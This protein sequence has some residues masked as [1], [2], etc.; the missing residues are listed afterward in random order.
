M[1]SPSRKRRGPRV[2]GGLILSGVGDQAGLRG[3]GVIKRAS[4]S[5]GIAFS[6]HTTFRQT[7]AAMEALVQRLTCVV[8]P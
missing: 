7:S 4:D 2:D 3:G 6:A 5:Y 1:S 8:G